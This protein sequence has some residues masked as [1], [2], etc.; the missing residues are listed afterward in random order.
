MSEEQ[1]QTNTAEGQSELTAVVRRE[2]R[3]AAIR[4]TPEMMFMLLNGWKQ[5][6]YIQLPNLNWPANAGF[7]SANW[8]VDRQA[9]FMVF[10][11]D[12]FPVVLEGDMIQVFSPNLEIIKV[13]IVDA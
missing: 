5:N 2:R 1:N 11:H 3:L 7:I 4:V 8:E 13:P 6:E 10:E 12:S 9:F